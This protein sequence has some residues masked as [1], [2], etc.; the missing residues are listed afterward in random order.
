MNLTDGSIHCGRRN[1]DGSGGNNHAVDHYEETKY[2]LAVKLGTITSDGK[3]DVFSYAEDNMV[4]DP[5]LKKH[6][7]HFGMNNKYSKI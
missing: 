5:Y 4:L 2:P 6:L 7:A 3:A 1:F